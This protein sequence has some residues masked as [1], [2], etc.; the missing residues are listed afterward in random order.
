[1]TEPD[2][3][4]IKGDLFEANSSKSYPATLSETDGALLLVGNGSSTYVDQEEIKISDAL[5]N[6]PTRVEFEDGR[7][8]LTRDRA[9]VAAVFGGSRLGGFKGMVANAEIFRP[10]IMAI[11]AILFLAAIVS[12]RYAMPFAMD[13]TAGLIPQTFEARLGA[14]AFQSF[15]LLLGDTE[16]NETRRAEVQTLFD[17]LLAASD[18]EVPIAIHIRHGGILNANA[19]ALPAGPVIVTDE[20]IK[21]APNDDALAGVLAHEIGHIEERH[22][23]R[24]MM[25]AAGWVILVS[26][27]AEEASGLFE[28]VAAFPTLL[29]DQAYSRSFE[30]DADDRAVEILRSAGRDPDQFAE[31]LRLITERCGTACDD[32]AW[33]SSHPAPSGRIDRIQNSPGALPE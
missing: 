23:L 2:S 33:L 13:F 31:M 9:A 12:L 8:F 17:E 4:V 32:S 11:L 22:G 14:V 29:I 28:E 18:V 16:T 25:R 6:V 24:R 27:V 3:V 19:F 1:M 15:D 30:T 7:V 10:R 21:L 20:L 5:A 26:I